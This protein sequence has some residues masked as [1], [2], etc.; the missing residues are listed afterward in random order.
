MRLLNDIRLGDGAAAVEE[1]AAQCSRP[2]PEVRKAESPT[3]HFNLY[4]HTQ[5]SPWDTPLADRKPS[6]CRTLMPTLTLL[7]PLRLCPLVRNPAVT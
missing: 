1:L 7:H 2:L 6:R 4:V 3:T 5:G